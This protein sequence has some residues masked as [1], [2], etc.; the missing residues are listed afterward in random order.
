M[1]IIKVG[2]SSGNDIVIQNDQYVGRT[3]CEFIMDDNGNYFVNDLNSTNGTFVNGVR[4]QGKTHLTPD[5]NVRIG[6]TTLAWV[7]FFNGMTLP[8]ENG[9]GYD[10]EP[11]KK[12]GCGF[13]IASLICSLVSLH[14]LGIIFGIVSLSRKEKPRGLGI[15]GLIVGALGLLVTIVVLIVIFAMDASYFDLFDLLYDLF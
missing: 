10:P 13:G 9:G 14:L 12:K 7:N 4:R 6:N 3:H 5:D 8:P 2:R 1:K 11:V 15:A